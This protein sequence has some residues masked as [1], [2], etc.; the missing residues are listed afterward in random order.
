MLSA[1]LA[2][3]SPALA[4][5]GQYSPSPAGQ[6]LAYQKIGNVTTQYP[7]IMMGEDNQIKTAII[8]AEGLWK[9]KL[10]DYLQNENHEAIKELISNTIQN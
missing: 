5:F 7:L 3:F 8:A 10:F 1:Q 2:K 4:P 9:W 6:V